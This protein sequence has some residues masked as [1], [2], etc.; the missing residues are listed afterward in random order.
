MRTIFFFLSQMRTLKL[1][2]PKGKKVPAVD[3]TYPAVAGADRQL[4]FVVHTA[5]FELLS[6][7]SSLRVTYEKYVVDT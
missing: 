7:D 2:S 5:L 6:A 3:S 4:P 1:A